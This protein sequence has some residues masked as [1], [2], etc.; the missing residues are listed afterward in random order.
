MALLD[1][2]K[3]SWEDIWK[4]DIYTTAGMKEGMGKIC[5]FKDVMDATSESRH[6]M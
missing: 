2:I 5:N 3:C 6:K 1:G 4:F